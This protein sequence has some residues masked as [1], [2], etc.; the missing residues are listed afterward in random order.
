MSDLLFRSDESGIFILDPAIRPLK[1]PPFSAQDPV[2][3]PSEAI[4][5]TTVHNQEWQR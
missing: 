2:C 1:T 4:L 5:L 3:C